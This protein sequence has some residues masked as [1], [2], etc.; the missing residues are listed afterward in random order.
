MSEMLAFCRLVLAT[1]FAIAA[2]AKQVDAEP[3]ALGWPALTGWPLRAAEVTV[4]GLLLPGATSPWGVLGAM[5]L[6]LG[7]VAF[8][9]HS[10]SR[11]QAG[12]CGCFGGLDRDLP[13]LVSLFRAAVILTMAGWGVME[14]RSVSNP[15]V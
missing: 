13:P 15:D 14:S 4:A 3:S 7:F 5:S 11:G 2:L 9:G 12:Q 10:M 1:V 6:A 8:I